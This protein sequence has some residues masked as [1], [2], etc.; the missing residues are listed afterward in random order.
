[1]GCGFQYIGK[2]GKLELC[3]MA[4]ERAVDFLKRE[5]K[6]YFNQIWNTGVIRAQNCNLC[7]VQEGTLLCNGLANKDYV[8]MKDVVPQILDQWLLVLL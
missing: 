2:L 1:M 4:Y 3:H 6:R 7:E 8:A 5:R